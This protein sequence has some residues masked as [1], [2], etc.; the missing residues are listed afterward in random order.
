V[1]DD[2]VFAGGM[3]TAPPA[4][5]PIAMVVNGTATETVAETAVGVATESESVERSALRV[6]R[7]RRAERA[8]GWYLDRLPAEVVKKARSRWRRGRVGSNGAET[9]PESGQYMCARIDGVGS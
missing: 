2:V 6:L 3:A 1:S 9:A 5:S 4:L 7:R 8:S